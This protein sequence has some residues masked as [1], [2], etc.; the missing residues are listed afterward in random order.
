MENLETQKVEARRGFLKKVAY[1]APAVVALGA[2]T[3]PVSAQ[4]SVVYHQTTAYKKG[5]PANVTEHYDNAGNYSVDGTFTPAGK[6]TTVWDRPAIVNAE[7]NWIQN[8]LNTM[9][10]RTV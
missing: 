2:L 1:A 4:A 7:G 6:G 5:V 8:F 3:A 10:G 9:F